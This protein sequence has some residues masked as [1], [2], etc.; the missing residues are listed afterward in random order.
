MVGLVTRIA[1]ITLLAGMVSACAISSI[2]S[3]F[4]SKPER[5]LTTPDV[6]EERL[7]DNEYG[8]IRDVVTGPDGLIYLLTD[9]NSGKLLRLSPV[10]SVA[11]K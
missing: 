5:A 10:E 11:A 9:S 7:L 2:T 6:S 1:V 8:R 3:P 4:R